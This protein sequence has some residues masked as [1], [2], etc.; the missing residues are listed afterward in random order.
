MNPG[1]KKR[2]HGRSN[3]DS[4]DHLSQTPPRSNQGYYAAPTNNTYFSNGIAPNGIT[5]NGTTAS[6]GRSPRASTNSV[7][8][9]GGHSASVNPTYNR[10]TSTSSAKYQAGSVDSLPSSFHNSY[11]RDS[12][13]MSLAKFTERYKKLLPLQVVVTK[14]YYGADERTS[15][16]EGDMFNIHFFKQTKVVKM[17]DTNN[18]TYTVPLNSSLEFGMVYQ[19]PDG[20]KQSDCKYHFKTVSDILQLK[21]LPKVVRAMKSFKGSN[22]ESSV[23]QHDLLMIQEV[24]VK[25]GIKSSKILKC[26]EANSGAKKSLSEDCAGCF[27]VRPQDV[28]LFLPEIVKFITLPQAAILSYGGGGRLD[29]PPHLISSQVTIKTMEFDESIVATSILEEDHRPIN[30]YENTPS[31]PLVDIPIDLDIEVAII[32][33]AEKD[34]DQLYFETR[35]LLEKYNPSMASYLNIDNSVTASAQSTLFKAIRQDQNQKIGI[36]ILQPE[37]AFKMSDIKRLSNSSD[38]SRRQL[39]TPSECANAEEVNGR[40]DSLENTWTMLETRLNKFELK[41]QTVD[42]GRPDYEGL[43]KE[44]MSVKSDVY[45]IRRDCDDFKKSIEGK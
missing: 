32:K 2:I 19:L 20:F 8:S 35:T 37:N 4:M 44:V 30:Q 21:T 7:D 25:R 13:E 45:K 5:S 22:P 24:K 39:G 12:K 17:V 38:S 29:L 6:N 36:E 43:K 23:E 40:L 14:G 33:L 27:S 16:S 18:Y 1:Q 26:V 31:L 15:I 10:Q 11:V 34:T 3:S 28:R 42:G 41:L 9:D